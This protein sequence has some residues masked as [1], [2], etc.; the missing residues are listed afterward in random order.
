[1]HITQVPNSIVKEIVHKFAILGHSYLPND[2]DFG[3]IEM[4]VKYSSYVYH[5]DQLKDI[6]ETC[7]V[8]K[9]A[10][11]VV[12]MGKNDFYCSANIVR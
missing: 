7:R 4:K 10:F 1:M 12:F 11:E 9:T 6:I 2:S 8:N 3:P 5:P